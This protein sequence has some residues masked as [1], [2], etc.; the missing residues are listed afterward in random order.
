MTL[1]V[2][3][4]SW[5]SSES[6]TPNLRNHEITLELTVLEVRV[7]FMHRKCSQM[8][9]RDLWSRSSSIISRS[10]NSNKA[11]RSSGT[12]QELTKKSTKRVCSIRFESTSITSN[13]ARVE[14]QAGSDR[15]R[16]LN[17]CINSR[18]IKNLKSSK[19]ST[20]DSIWGF[21]SLILSP[22]ASVAAAPAGQAQS[23]LSLSRCIALP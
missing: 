13:V 11:S 4:I 12:K 3:S 22:R 17:L 16:W 18:E 2:N 23:Q 10:A 7:Y 9:S 15:P 20:E 5:N 21:W 1:S 14:L 19:L 8:Q 6:V